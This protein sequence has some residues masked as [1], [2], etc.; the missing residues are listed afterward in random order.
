MFLKI[1]TSR[2]VVLKS[3]KV[4]VVVGS[5]LAIINH[6]GAILDWDLSFETI[7]KILLSYLVPYLVSTYSAATTIQNNNQP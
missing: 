2:R 4:S 5:L 7:I 3:L 1:A 6:S